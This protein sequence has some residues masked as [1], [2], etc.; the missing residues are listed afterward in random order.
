M[1]ILAEKLQ[2][3]EVLEK[4]WTHLMVDF[5]IKL[6]L[7]ARKNAILVIYD[8]LSKIT[9]FVAT[10]ERTSAE[11]LAQLFRNNI[12]KLYRL[13]ESIVLDRKPVCSGV[14]KEVEQN[15]RY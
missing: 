8:R 6:L 5:I 9:H 7:V 15:I 12:Q 14:N 2:L 1:E 13:P 4:L 11:R 10:I 3:S